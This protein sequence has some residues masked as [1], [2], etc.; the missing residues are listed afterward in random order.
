MQGQVLSDVRKML[1]E[2]GPES[3]H[4]LLAS[5]EG[6]TAMGRLQGNQA[7]QMV[8]DAWQMLHE[9]RSLCHASSTKES[10]RETEDLQD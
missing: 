1:D 6:E 2:Y 7:F 4:N 3:A 5:K 9:N 10:I 8:R